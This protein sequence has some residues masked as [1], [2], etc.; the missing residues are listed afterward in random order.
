M[1]AWLAFWMDGKIRRSKTFSSKIHGFEPARIMAIEFLKEKRKENG[2]SSPEYE[3]DGACMPPLPPPRPLTRARG[4]IPSTAAPTSA[5]SSLSSTS[6]PAT[7][8]G[9]P[10]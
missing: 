8:L 9:K 1:Q 5:R 10:V 6:T 2:L 3:P 4:S 7:E